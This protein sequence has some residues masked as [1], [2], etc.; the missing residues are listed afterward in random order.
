MARVLHH[1]VFYCDITGAVTDLLLTLVILLAAV[2]VVIPFL[3]C[4]G[5][6]PIFTMSAQQNQL[7]DLTE[8]EFNSFTSSYSY[9]PVSSLQYYTYLMQY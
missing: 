9:T 8:E 2:L 7:K 1:A 5:P 4:G 3:V 6:Q